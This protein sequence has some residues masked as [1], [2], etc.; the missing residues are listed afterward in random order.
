MELGNNYE[1]NHTSK[2]ILLLNSSFIFI[3]FIGL[4]KMRF[5]NPLLNTLSS[6]PDHGK[7]FRIPNIITIKVLLVLKS[8][9]MEKIRAPK[10]ST[11]GIKGEKY[12][13]EN[14]RLIK[15]G[16]NKNSPLI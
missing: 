8:L 5:L 13:Y 7:R 16:Q 15:K 1:T 10:G 6:F 9:F 14:G 3:V 4:H 11:Q 12:F 2:I